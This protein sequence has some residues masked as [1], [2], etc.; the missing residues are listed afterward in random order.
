MNTNKCIL[1]IKSAYYNY[2]WRSCDTED[3]INDA[4]KYILI[5]GINTI[6]KWI[7]MENSYFKLQ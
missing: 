1:S 7:E 6:L 3:W 5:T 2:F 4:E